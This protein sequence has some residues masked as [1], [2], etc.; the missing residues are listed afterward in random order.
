[1]D[2]DDLAALLVDAPAEEVD[3]IHRLLH[4]WSVG[5]DSSFPFRISRGESVCEKTAKRT[6]WKQH[7]KFMSAKKFST[8][9]KTDIMAE[10]FTNNCGLL[11]SKSVIWQ[12]EK[13]QL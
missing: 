10:V 1:M 8:L 3:Q 2:K 7:F 12:N 13:R 6:E 9:T 4:D 11:Q 5:P